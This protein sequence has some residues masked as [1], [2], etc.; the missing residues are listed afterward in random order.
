MKASFK[1]QFVSSKMFLTITSFMA[2]S[3]FCCWPIV[4]M[5]TS[6]IDGNQRSCRSV[7][8][9]AGM[10]AVESGRYTNSQP[11]FVCAANAGGEGPRAGFN[12]EPNWSTACWVGHGGREVPIGDYKCL[13][14]RDSARLTWV[15][16][17]QQSCRSVCSAKNASALT[18]GTYRN[19]EPF[20]V[21]ATNADGEGFRP[22]YNLEPD[23]STRCW[24]GRGG[25]EVG[26]SPYKCLCEEVVA[27]SGFQPTWCRSSLRD[28]PIYS[29][30]THWNTGW[31]KVSRPSCR[32]IE[33][34][35]R[36]TL[37]CQ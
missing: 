7:C 23:W 30:R 25:R 9:S 16:S 12:L 29:P 4:S 17:S 26:Y 18:T 19:G 5:A 28:G 32:C 10:T 27:D 3:L 35:S 6:M 15:D 33:L 8:S 20:F 22:G 14:R 13:C 11:Y 34:V 1:S 36:R 2:I 21:C 31:V 37:S 24:V